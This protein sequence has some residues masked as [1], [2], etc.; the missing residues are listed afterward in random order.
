MKIGLVN[1]FKNIFSDF[2]DGLLYKLGKRA[3]YEENRSGSKTIIKEISD[4]GILDKATI[5]LTPTAYSD[6][7]LHSVKTQGDEL[8]TNGD[9]AT[10]SDW[11]EG[12]GW[13]I[14][15]TTKVADRSGETGNSAMS[16]SIS[17]V[18]GK[19]YKFSYT[20]NYI[21]GN[22]ETNI[23]SKLDNVSYTTLGS[24]TSTV[25]EEH[26]VTGI[27]V[28]GFTGSMGLNVY[29]IGT[30]TGNIDNISVKDVSSDF[31]FE[32][33]SSATRVDSDGLI[34]DMQSITDPELVENGDFS[35][36]SSD[37]GTNMDFSSGTS[38]WALNPNWSLGGV[39]VIA[40]GTSNSTVWQ[41]SVVQD[42]KF[43]K[44]TY[45][46]TDF[47]QGTVN[48]ELGGT[49][50]ISRTIAGTY[51]EILQAGTSPTTRITFEGSGSFK[52]TLSN[53]SV[54]QLDPDDDWTLGTGWSLGDGELVHTG[55]GDYAVQGSLT[56]G[57][58]YEV[59]IVVTQASGS[60]FP[61]IYM[62]GLTTAM[63]SPDTYTFNITAQSGDTIKLRG[64]NDCKVASVSVI[65]VTFSEDVDLPRIDY[66]GG[67][68]HILLEPASTNLITY[69]E[70]FSQSDWTK[71]DITVT[72]NSTTSPDGTNNATKLTSTA[73]YAKIT[74]T[75]TLSATTDYTVSFYTKNIDA[76]NPKISI[77]DNDNSVSL[78]SQT[79]GSSLSTSEWVRIEGSFTTTSGTS[80]QVQIVRDL[81]DTEEMYIWG[82]Q[83]EALSYAT[84]Y[85]PT[86]GTTVTRDAETCNSA[87]TSADF[88]SEE[89]VFYAE[90][91][92]LADDST[93][94]RITMSDGTTNNRMAIGF[95]NASNK[96]KYFLISS[97]S[98]QVN[99][100]VSVSN[101][102]QFNK[103]AFKYKL[104]D[105][106]LWVN[107]VEVDTDTLGSTFSA[108]T[109]SVLSFAGYSGTTQY[110]YGK[111]K[112]IK[113]Y[114][115]ALSDAELIALTT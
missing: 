67:V 15:T 32:R 46:L 107:G 53:I 1:T 96:I 80:I 16:Q 33:D 93:D 94:R 95:D 61:Q 110:F 10:D 37:L 79:Y 69:S 40:D 7:R 28:A 39:G 97:N 34:Q 68:G 57:N 59:V 54:K 51:T 11:T 29:G 88:N 25:V 9:F 24:Y 2:I 104:N 35:E 3:T 23:Y 74:D 76:V 36:I 64:L 4:D 89:G 20:R 42:N 43:Y 26:T 101:I 17:V 71:N 70:D 5:L 100:D 109:L 75:L 19:S 82:A 21:S 108:N 78:L 58:Q 31:D 56:T 115:E 48:V 105:F 63:T 65:D 81:Q 103:I 92:A 49:N 55:S 50:G 66:T 60:D 27:F 83:V 12:A 111:C 77:W 106:A 13:D 85:I 87:G 47:T 38:P 98:T 52:V 14:N 45:T 90:I 6:A 8:I 102:T 18:N 91:A 41:N 72:L 84:S 86:A 113:V 112:A 44:V 30:F 73:D 22:G 114:K 62:G 99:A